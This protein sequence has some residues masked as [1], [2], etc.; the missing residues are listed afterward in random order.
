[1]A[2]GA[3][4]ATG[5]ASDLAT[6]LSPASAIHFF[7]KLALAAPASFFSAEAFSQAAAGLGAA[8]M[9]PASARHFF[10]KLALAAPASFFSAEAFSQAAAGSAA[11]FL[12]LR[13]SFIKALR[14]S[15]FLPS[16]SL[17]QAP[18][19]LCWAVLASPSAACTSGDR[20]MENANATAIRDISF[21]MEVPVKV[22]GEFGFS[23]ESVKDSIT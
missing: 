10:S 21:F 19:L 17:L 9:P 12:A 3:V 18:I 5:L 8:A 2:A 15:P 4:A 13:H 7:S 1:L 22:V 14:A 16:A 23:S 20:L 6:V 11:S